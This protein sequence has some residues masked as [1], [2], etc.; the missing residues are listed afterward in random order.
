MKR[1]NG[2][3]ALLIIALVLFATSAKP[4]AATTAVNCTDQYVKCLNDASKYNDSSVLQSM[5]ET[6][7]GFEYT[8]CVASKLKFW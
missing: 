6:E 5:A 4:A 7:C 2:I 1:S 8:G 3:F